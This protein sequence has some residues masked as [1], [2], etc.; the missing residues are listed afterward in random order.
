MTKKLLTATALLVT[1]A[2]TL[3][4]CSDDSNDSN[5]S[6]DAASNT[7]ADADTIVV[8]NCGTTYEL[9]GPPER[10]AELHIPNVPTLDALGVFDSV[11]A[12]GG[13]FLPEYFS[14]ELNAK[15]D[16]VE[17][18]SEDLAPDGHIEI[19]REAVVATNPDIII[20]GST[21]V[22]P[23]SMAPND[24]P[25][26]QEEGACGGLDGDASWDDIDTHIDLWATTFDK[27]DEGEELKASVEDD[28]AE[29]RAT[30]GSEEDR[31][32]AVLYPTIGG[33]VTYAYGRGSMA[34]PI[35]ETAGLNN[36]FSEQSDRVFEVN[37]EQIVDHSPEVIVALYNEGDPEEVKQ[38]VRELQGADTM[39]AVQ[40]DNIIALPI[41]FL[42]YASL[43]N[44]DGLER[45]QDA[46]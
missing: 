14:D 37:A 23:E 12:K 11:I 7:D 3:S 13:V 19:S 4:A 2:L 15:L 35:V 29:A 41:F 10:V 27:H 24:I 25:V 5:V 31:S 1:A 32:V 46:L 21:N 44:L 33:G 34:H 17:S 8:E 22:T 26:I 43:L 20:G 28:L 39:P 9:D 45:L 40:E 38:A 36:V 16:G 6:T 30:A 18:L 42:E